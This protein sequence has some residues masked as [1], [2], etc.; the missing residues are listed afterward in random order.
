[1]KI[2]DGQTD[3]SSLADLGSVAVRLLCSGDFTALATQ[4]GYALAYDRDPAVAIREE[5]AL[6]LSDL[7]AS[8]LGPPPDQLPSVSYF[9]PNDTRLFALVEQYIP[10]DR[11]G[12]VLLELI[13]SSQG[14]DKHVVLEQIS[15]AA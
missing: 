8:T 6:S 12:H 2:M 5:L 13:V 1:M 3:V 4:F 10:T 9:E 14:A 15:A 11:T 7:G